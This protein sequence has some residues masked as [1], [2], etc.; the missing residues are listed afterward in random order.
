LFLID[1]DL[2]NTLELVVQINLRSFHLLGFGLILFVGLFFKIH[3]LNAIFK[4]HLLNAIFKMHLLN[5]LFNLVESGVARA[6]IE[7]VAPCACPS[8]IVHRGAHE[9]D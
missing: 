1:E 2:E 8:C 9:Q 6:R 4:I 3:L 5:A 7:H